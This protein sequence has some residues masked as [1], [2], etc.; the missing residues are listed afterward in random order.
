MLQRHRHDAGAAVD[1]DAAEELQSKTWCEILALLRTAAF[2]KH[3]LWTE[4]VIQLAGTP[5]P[6]MKR[7]GDEFRERLEILKHRAIWCV[8]VRGG[9][10]HV[11]PHPHGVS[12]AR[13]F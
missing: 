7:A 3:R 6:R 2:L 4:S 5:G 9:L 8:M 13:T 11:G 1:I 10:G 12:D